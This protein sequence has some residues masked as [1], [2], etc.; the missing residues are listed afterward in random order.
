M[1]EGILICNVRLAPNLGMAVERMVS[2]QVTSLDQYHTATLLSSGKQSN[3]VT[4]RETHLASQLYTALA[5]SAVP[6]LTAY[7]KCQIVVHVVVLQDDGNLLSACITAASLALADACI[8]MNDLVTCC[9]VALIQQQQPSF[10]HSTTTVTNS[11]KEPEWIL[12]ADPDQAEED[13]S[14]AMVTLC[15]LPNWK[16]VTLWEQSGRMSSTQLQQAMELCRD[17]CR[18]LHRLMRTSLTTNTTTTAYT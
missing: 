4:T 15:L 8:E 10:Q 16:Q 2:T 7:P 6:P 11:R 17:G 9:R 14:A 5:S 3:L 18:T 13:A 1:E 12:L